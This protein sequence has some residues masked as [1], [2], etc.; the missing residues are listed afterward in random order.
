MIIHSGYPQRVA[1]IKH[2]CTYVANADKSNL[3]ILQPNVNSLLATQQQ[4]DSQNESIKVLN[5]SGYACT[6]L[7]LMYCL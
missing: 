7:H 2:K 1:I 4:S 6:S 3:E 5:P